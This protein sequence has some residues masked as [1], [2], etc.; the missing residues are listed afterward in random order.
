MPSRRSSS[1]SRRG[2]VVSILA[3]LFGLFLLWA[4]GSNKLTAFL[5]TATPGASTSAVTPHTGAGTTAATLP[6]GAAPSGNRNLL[7]GNPSGATHD[8]S[9]PTNYLIERPQYALSY[10]RDHGIPNWVS[11]QITP[12]DL[13]NTKRNDKFVPDTTLP[14]GWYQVTLDDYTGTG[15]DRGHLCP[16]ADRTASAKDNQATFIMTNIQPQAPGNNRATWEHLEAFSRDLVDQGH[17]LYVIAGGDGKDG[18]IAKGKVLVPS[19]TW[20]IVVVMP[21]GESDIRRITADTPVIAIRVPNGL[22]DKLDDWEHYRVT[23]A[24]IEEATGYHFFTNLAPDIQKALKSRVAPV[25]KT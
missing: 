13:G 4:Y 15:Y 3:A 2:Q 5:P 6:P 17:V 19:N 16:S 9:Q 24:E 25:P 8:P 22:K 14:K 1:R 23:V 20:K 7:L 18:T 12:K 10:N 11:W 21:K